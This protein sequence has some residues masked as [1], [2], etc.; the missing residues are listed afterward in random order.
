MNAYSFFLL[1][2][3]YAIVV[4]INYNLASAREMERR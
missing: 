3:G 1:L 2:T 4:E